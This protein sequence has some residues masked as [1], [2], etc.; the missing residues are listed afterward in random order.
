MK[1]DIKKDVKLDIK[2]SDL[3]K[4]IIKELDGLYWQIKNDGTIYWSNSK[5]NIQRI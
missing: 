1:L 4:K 2:L 5:I 3:D